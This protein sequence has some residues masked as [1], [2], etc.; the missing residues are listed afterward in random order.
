MHVHFQLLRENFWLALKVVCVH[1]ELTASC[2]GVF[3]PIHIFCFIYLFLSPHPFE[4][5]RG[6]LEWTPFSP[7]AR[8]S[9]IWPYIS[10][11]NKDSVLKFKISSKQNKMYLKKKKIFALG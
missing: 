4:K 3:F 7:A 10:V 11:A 1:K 9:H 2:A 6:V 5:W 8:L